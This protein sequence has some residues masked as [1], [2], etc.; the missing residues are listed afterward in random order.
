MPEILRRARHRASK[1]LPTQGLSAKASHVGEIM[2]ALLGYRTYAALT[3]EYSDPSVRLVL[4]DAQVLVLNKPAGLARAQ[5]VL[6]VL[7]NAQQQAVVTCCI[8]SL[9]ECADRAVFVGLDDLYDSWLREAIAQAIY[10]AEE[11]IQS[12]HVFAWPQLPH[13]TPI[14]VDL[15]TSSQEWKI[16][17]IGTMSEMS[18]GDDDNEPVRLSPTAT[19][20]VRG[21]FFFQKA[22]RAGLVVQN[23]GGSLL[24]E[25][26]PQVLSSQLRS[27]GHAPVPRGGLH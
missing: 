10:D 20:A 4:E 6:D 15:W 9:T 18:D 11:V 13:E 27:R 14:T 7:N 3:Q 26:D 2:A 19:V 25:L 16:E 8:D 22:G 17:A 21:G 12:A 24:R 1:V 23:C 5:S